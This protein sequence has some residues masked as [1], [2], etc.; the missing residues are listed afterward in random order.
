MYYLGF[1]IGGSSMKA[2]LVKDKKI[3]KSQVKDSPDN[4]EALLDLILKLY[5][6]LISEVKPEEIGGV[7]FAIAGVLDKER[8]KMLNS[9]NISYLNNQPIKKLFEEKVGRSII[10]EHDVHCFLAAEKEVGIARNFKNIF[11]LAIGTGVGGAYMNDGKIQT[12]ALGAAGEIG[13]IIID[14]ENGRDLESLIGNKYVKDKLGVFADE[15]EKLARQGD[16]KAKEVFVQR[17]KNL[18]VGI[19][20]II[21]ILNP[22]VVIIGGGIASAQDMILPGIKEAVEKYVTSPE[23][24]KTPI[25]F[26]ELGQFGGALGAAIIAEESLT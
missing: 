16:L 8:A 14:K 9:P 17:A 23:A 5:R 24:K 19:A 4:L 7:G 22:E 1:D 2:A 11:Y 20:N 12:G 6:D 15:A 26:S 21:N 18:G 10:I 13:H 3:I 25:L